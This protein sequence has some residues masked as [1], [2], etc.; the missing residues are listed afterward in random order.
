MTEERHPFFTDSFV[1][2]SV[3]REDFSWILLEVFRREELEEIAK[4]TGVRPYGGIQFHK[5]SDW[6]L[7][8]Y[9]ADLA[10][11]DAK[12]LKGLAR[13]IGERLPD[14]LL[15][16]RRLSGPQIDLLIELL[17]NLPYETTL[18][19]VVRLLGDED[20]KVRARAV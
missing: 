9:V 19:L 14:P 1:L 18:P 17:R 4:K 2:E 20:P 10:Y 13:R 11:D 5:M 3:K 8:D 12:F 7:S 15:A 6:E 16:G